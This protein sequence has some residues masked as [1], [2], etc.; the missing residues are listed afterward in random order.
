MKFKNSLLVLL[1]FFSSS[2]L[3]LYGYDDEF[4]EIFPGDQSSE[5]MTIVLTKDCCEVSRFEVNLDILNFLKN[6][7][8]KFPVLD[9]DNILYID[10]KPWLK[11]FLSFLQVISSEKVTGDL[12][13]EHVVTWLDKLE[14][15]DL[16]KTGELC[17]NLIHDF[18][19]F[20]NHNDKLRK[21]LQEGYETEVVIEI[22]DIIRGYTYDFDAVKKRI[23]NRIARSKALSGSH[24]IEGVIRVVI[25]TVNSQICELKSQYERNE[26]IYEIVAA[27][28]TLLCFISLVI[29]VSVPFEDNQN[30]IIL[31]ISEWTIWFGIVIICF[32]RSKNLSN[33]Y[34]DGLDNYEKV[35]KF[36]R[37]LL[38]EIPVEL[39]AAIPSDACV[40]EFGK[41]EDV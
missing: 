21:H 12:L 35:I 27:V 31:G 18:G 13:V 7:S 33:A 37:D 28:T 22:K 32:F 3:F 19:K 26:K 29:T 34:G 2:T 36:L 25:D 39:L 1:L 38:E 40:I 8:L 9:K 5:K 24:E 17:E 16:K 6:G 11:Y 15:S 30:Q 20:M 23:R 14:A 41:E 4:L 10:H